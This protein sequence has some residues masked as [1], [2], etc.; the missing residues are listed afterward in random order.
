MQQAE[1]VCSQNRPIFFVRFAGPSDSNRS[2]EVQS[3]RQMLNNI[4]DVDVD[5]VFIHQVGNL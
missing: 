1:L 3:L 2:V 4:I 5:V